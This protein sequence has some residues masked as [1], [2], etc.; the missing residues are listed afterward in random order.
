MHVQQGVEVSKS[1]RSRLP[2]DTPTLIANIKRRKK[3]WLRT[4][5]EGK[6]EEKRPKGRK[7][8]IVLDDIKDGITY[9]NLKEKGL[10][11]VEWKIIIM[12]D[13]PADYLRRYI[14]SSTYIHHYWYDYKIASCMK[15]MTVY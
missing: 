5:F 10:D 14:H 9:D 7:R 12:R 15:L 13:L 11:R 3:D 2:D 8:I 4:V 6:L 1:A